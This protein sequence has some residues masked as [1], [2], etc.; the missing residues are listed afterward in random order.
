MVF[1]DLPEEE[2]EKRFAEINAPP[3]LPQVVEA[4]PPPPPKNLQRKAVKALNPKK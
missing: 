1:R 3:S 4:V 2:A